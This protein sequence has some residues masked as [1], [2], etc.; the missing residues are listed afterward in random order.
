[1]VLGII[2]LVLFKSVQQPAA[3]AIQGLEQS[4]GDLKMVAFDLKM[5]LGDIKLE[6]GNL[7]TEVKELKDEIRKG[8]NPI[9]FDITAAFVFLAILVA[10]LVA[11][12]WR[13]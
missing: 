2:Q 9:V 4:S 13:K 7:K 10:V 12:V 8:K 11:I 6:I 5:Q 1:M 3:T